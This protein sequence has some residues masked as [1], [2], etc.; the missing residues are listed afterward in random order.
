MLISF[1]IIC[2]PVALIKLESVWFIRVLVRTGID[3]ISLIFII[4]I[5]TSPN[6]EN[7]EAGR[8]INSYMAQLTSKLD[9]TE[10]ASERRRPPDTE[11]NIDPFGSKCCPSHIPL[12]IFQKLTLIWSWVRVILS[13][14]VQSTLVQSTE[15]STNVNKQPDMS[16][17][18]RV[19]ST[20]LWDVSGLYSVPKKNEQN[21]K[22]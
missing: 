20:R 18:S 15:P 4:F 11:R 9:R 1:L 14:T 17:R 7:T 8:P 6:T 22:K 21:P 19:Q 13:H 10:T 16:R 5:I 12:F 2:L 3:I